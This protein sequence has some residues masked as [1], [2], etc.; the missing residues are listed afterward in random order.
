MA[1]ETD[2]A[3]Q[4]ATSFIALLKKNG[5]DVSEAY[6]FG[7]AARGEADKESDIDVAIV[8]KDFGGIPFYD[9]RKI[10][11][12]RRQVDL[13]LE[14]HTF[15]LHDLEAGPSLF[16]NKIKKEGIQLKP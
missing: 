10:S 8:S 4:K 14:I 5:I 6:L 16:F 11:R 12:Y 13:R 2:I 9:I 1:A 3:S 15:S 7:S